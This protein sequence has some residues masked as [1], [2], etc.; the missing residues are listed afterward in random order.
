[1]ENNEK[2]MDD[3]LFNLKFTVSKTTVSCCIDFHY[4][5]YYEDNLH[6]LLHMRRFK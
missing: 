1:M 4:S 6:P 2:V 3:Y 5:L